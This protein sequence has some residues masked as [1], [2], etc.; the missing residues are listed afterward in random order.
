MNPPA[1]F[2][3][4]IQHFAIVL[5]EGKNMAKKKFTTTLEEGLLEKIKIQA[6]REKRPV[7]DL[8][9]ELIRAYLNKTSRED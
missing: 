3:F 2:L 6:I 4:P 9:E 1:L 5:K 7:S 8:L